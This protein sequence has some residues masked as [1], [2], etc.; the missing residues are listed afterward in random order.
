[1]RGL[2]DSSAWRLN[3]G[4]QILA[5]CFYGDLLLSSRRGVKGS[6]AFLMMKVDPAMIHDW[7]ALHFLNPNACRAS[8]TPLDI[9]EIGIDHV[10][11]KF[12]L[13]NRRLAHSDISLGTR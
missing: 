2:F 8:R 4:L 12:A 6:V 9:I 10:R 1:M 11:T 13:Y 7:E 3:P 5:N